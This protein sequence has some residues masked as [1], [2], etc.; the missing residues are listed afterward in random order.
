MTKK[1]RP[2]GKRVLVQRIPEEE[3][4]GNLLLVAPRPANSGIIVAM[5]DGYNLWNSDSIDV[6]YQ[7]GD[8]VL[9]SHYAGLPLEINGEEYLMLEPDQILAKFSSV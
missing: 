4:R 8:R 1:I 9:I 3:R 7:V 6:P 5:G 2:L